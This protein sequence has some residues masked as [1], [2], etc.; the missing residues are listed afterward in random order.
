MTSKEKSE[1]VRSIMDE[2]NYDPPGDQFISATEFYSLPHD[3]KLKIVLRQV[4]FAE[5]KQVNLY[6]RH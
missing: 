3:S 1:E 2:F 5:K 6:H 4:E